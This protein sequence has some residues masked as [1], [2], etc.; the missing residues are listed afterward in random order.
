MDSSISVLRK[1]K[2]KL[3][4]IGEYTRAFDRDNDVPKSIDNF[5]NKLLEYLGCV[6][7]NVEFRKSCSDDNQAVLTSLKDV[8]SAHSRMADLLIKEYR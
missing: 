8:V 5:S 6:M 7:M 3:V 1:S 2:I 4:S